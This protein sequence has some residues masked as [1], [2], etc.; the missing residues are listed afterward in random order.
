MF[1]LGQPFFESFRVPPA[2]PGFCPLFYRVQ[3]GKND[4]KRPGGF[5]F[6]EGEPQ[7][8]DLRGHLPSISCFI[9]LRRRWFLLACFWNLASWD[10]MGGE[11][12][13]V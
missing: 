10:R 7:W 4:K 1:A 8:V 9:S 13:A 12:L 5:R 6:V 2:P 3:V 11:F